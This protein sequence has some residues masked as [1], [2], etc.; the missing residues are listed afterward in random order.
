MYPVPAGAERGQRQIDIMANGV[1]LHHVAQRPAKYMRPA[2][3]RARPVA[4]AGEPDGV[5]VMF[6]RG[7]GRRDDVGVV[8]GR[9]ATVPW[10]S[11][12]NVL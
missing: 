6:A 4:R 10:P 7:T 2:A 3:A 1:M 5:H 11:Y 9:G 12:L 8:C